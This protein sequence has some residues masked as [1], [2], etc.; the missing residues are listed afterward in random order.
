M[1]ELLPLDLEDPLVLL[2]PLMLLP[3]VL[4]PLVELDEGEACRL[5]LPASLSASRRPFRTLQT[6]VQRS[7][8][9]TFL[10]LWLQCV[11]ACV[12]TEAQHWSF[13]SKAMTANYDGRQAEAQ[14]T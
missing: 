14:Q 2:L 13:A 7:D 3:E 4:L 12:H 8:G 11:T 6:E 9:M 10:E 5:V 1:L